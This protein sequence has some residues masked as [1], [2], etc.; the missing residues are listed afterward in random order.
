M[1][2]ILCKLLF[3]F[4]GGASVRSP[5]H[6]N[7]SFVPI[8]I[9]T[10]LVYIADITYSEQSQKPPRSL[11]PS[12]P[13]SLPDLITKRWNIAGW[14]EARFISDIIDKVGQTTPA[15]LTHWLDGSMSATER[16]L[17]HWNT[18]TLEHC[19]TGTLDWAATI[20]EGVSQSFQR[21]N[22]AWISIQIVLISIY[23]A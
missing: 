11:P 3:C 17:E 23:R 21:K 2:S 20:W 10:P 1:W 16:R 5:T 15:Q 7:I 22:P 9:K 6:L 13:P 4:S 14:D 19:N 18:G 12:L 8:K